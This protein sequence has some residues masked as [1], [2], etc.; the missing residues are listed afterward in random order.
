MVIPMD[1]LKATAAVPP[2]AP[3]DIPKQD[4]KQQPER[5]ALPLHWRTVLARLI[6]FGGALIIGSIGT[7]QMYL[8]LG[9]GNLTT[10]FLLG[11]F[12][13]IGDIG[14]TASGFAEKRTA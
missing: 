8:A 9:S 1:R 6:A 7:W 13:N 11:C 2:D 14:R 10:N 12:L 5:Q 4:L 3:L